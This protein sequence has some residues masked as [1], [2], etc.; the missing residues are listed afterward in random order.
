MAAKAMRGQALSETAA[1]FLVGMTGFR[2]DLTVRKSKGP[3][4]PINRICDFQASNVSLS[5][6]YGGLSCLFFAFT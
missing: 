4:S 1:A 6:T 5:P 3:L 2:Q